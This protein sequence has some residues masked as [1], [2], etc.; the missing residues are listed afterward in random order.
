[1]GSPGCLG[2]AVTLPGESAG[3]GEGSPVCL[4]SAVTLP[5]ESA[6]LGGG[7]PCVSRQCCNRYLVKVLVWGRAALGV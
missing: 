4:G 1:M 5:G 7:Q 2:S 6:G 3:L